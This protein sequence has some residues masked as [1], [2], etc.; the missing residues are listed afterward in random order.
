MI[1]WPFYSSRNGQFLCI[2]YSKQGL[3]IKG[4]LPFFFSKG[5]FSSY[6]YQQNHICDLF[7]L[8]TRIYMIFKKTVITILYFRYH[9]SHDHCRKNGRH[10]KCFNHH[11]P[12]PFRQNSAGSDFSHIWFDWNLQMA[13]LF[14][15]KTPWLQQ[16]F[17]AC[18]QHTLLPEK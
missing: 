17:I 9:L 15:R 7:I 8:S 5:H 6:I 2:I 12:Y 16:F 18:V 14:L 11:K 13:A 3:H 1:K 10:F 4:I